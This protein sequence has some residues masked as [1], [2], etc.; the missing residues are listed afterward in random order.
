MR[1]CHSNLA[2]ITRLRGFHCVPGRGTHLH[3]TTSLRTALLDCIFWVQICLFLTILP[4]G[5]DVSNGSSCPYSLV[6]VCL[7]F[8]HSV[9]FKASTSVILEHPLPDLLYLYWNKN[10][11]QNV[12]AKGYF[13]DGCFLSSIELKEWP[14]FATWELRLAPPP[15]CSPT[16]TAWGPTWRR[17]AAEVIAYFLH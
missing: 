3:L 4:H 10:I 17:Q 14:P 13:P 5:A 8:V 15:R 6:S 1:C 11:I 7:L 9:L 2:W 16:T 12:G